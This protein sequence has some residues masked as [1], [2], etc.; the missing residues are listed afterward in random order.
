[1]YVT[2]SFCQKNELLLDRKPPR[3]EAT[4]LDGQVWVC[5][6][7]WAVLGRATEG[8]EILSWTEMASL[9]AQDAGFLRA[10]FCLLCPRLLCHPGLLSDPALA[11]CP[12]HSQC[13]DAHSRDV[14]LD[15]S[16]DSL[17]PTSSV[18]E[19]SRWSQ[20][21][22]SVPSALPAGPWAP[23]SVILLLSHCGH[24]RVNWL[25]LR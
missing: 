17:L 14:L 11:T 20:Q 22:L 4:E 5:P 2:I 1:M 8:R 18:L 25:L 9:S 12:L 7:Q 24:L 6:L 3:Q 13:G 21:M 23:G 16:I 15:V 10:D 19:T